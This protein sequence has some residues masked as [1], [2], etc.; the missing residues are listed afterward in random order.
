MDHFYVLNMALKI[1][2]EL[3]RPY[4]NPD[5]SL[6]PVPKDRHLPTWGD[7]E[8]VLAIISLVI[9]KIFYWRKKRTMENFPNAAIIQA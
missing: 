5:R 3:Y 1:Q 6:L 2:E 9:S 4:K 8:E 7:F